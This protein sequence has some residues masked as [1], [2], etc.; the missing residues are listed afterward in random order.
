[1]NQEER[2]IYDYFEGNITEHETHFAYKAGEKIAW[3]YSLTFEGYW[4]RFLDTDFKVYMS[5]VELG[6]FVVNVG[7]SIG[8][9][10][11]IIYK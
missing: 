2:K 10:E 5:L 6:R 7:I 8:S 3:G 11:K 4:V 1:M 9:V